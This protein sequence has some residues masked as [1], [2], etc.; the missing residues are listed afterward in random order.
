MKNLLL[1]I[2]INFNYE[3][4]GSNKNWEVFSLISLPEFNNELD[5]S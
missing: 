5:G 1:E 2:K 4:K 3:I